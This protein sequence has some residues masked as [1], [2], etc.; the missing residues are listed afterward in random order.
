MNPISSKNSWV[1]DFEQVAWKPAADES[2]SR[3][4]RMKAR[5]PYSAA[6]PPMI[7]DLRI[8]LDDSVAAE[9]AEAAAEIARFDAE[10]SHTLSAIGDGEF[11]PLPAVLLRSESASSSQI[12]AITANAKSLALASIGEQTG[13]N[14]ALVATNADAMQK[15]LTLS[16]SITVESIIDVHRSLLAP[17]NPAITGEFRS[18]P[19][20]IGGRASTPHTAAYVPPQAERVPGLMEDLVAFAQ[21]TD[22][23]PFVQAAVAHA[24]FETIHPFPDGNGRVGRTL[25]HAMLR[26]AGVTKRLTIPVSSGLL[27]NVDDYYDALTDYRRGDLNSIVDEFTKASFR[28][29][30]NGRVMINDL[31]KISAEWQSRLSARKGAAAWSA[32]PILIA[33]PAVSVQYVADRVGVTFAAAQNAIN[34][35]V[36]AEILTPVGNRKRSRIWVATEVIE[37]LDA[38]AARAGKRSFGG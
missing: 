21:R 23:P 30:G 22:V 29:I 10:S 33:Q 20:W 35:L 31:A 36:Q 19:V 27:T 5:G 17:S 25:V 37:V 26:N 12:E 28:S 13:P 2:M 9:A 7:A 8:A 16:D 4:Q 18:D 1:V 11:S 24:Q 34:Q 38:F 15:A 3:S 6:I 14:A 32:L